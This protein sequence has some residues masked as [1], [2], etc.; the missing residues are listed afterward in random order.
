MFLLVLDLAA[1]ALLTIAISR[2]IYKLS[3]YSISFLLIDLIVFV[4]AVISTVQSLKSGVKFSENSLEFTGLDKDN[5]YD[6]STIQKAEA[7]K[8]TSASLKKGFVERYSSIVLH[9]ND[10]TV[11]VIELGYT[12]KKK[13]KLILDEI[14]KRCRI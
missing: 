5:V 7:V 10:G 4:T 13:L 3:F 12:S 6:Y 1:I 2:I 14:K 8:D 11:A 9:L